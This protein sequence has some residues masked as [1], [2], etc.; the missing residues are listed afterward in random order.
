MKR[1]NER[2][3]RQD[4]AEEIS[5]FWHDTAPKTVIKYLADNKNI[6]V[7]YHQAYYK[8][9]KKVKKWKDKDAE[10]LVDDLN[11]GPYEYAIEFDE[12]PNGQCVL[13]YIS[14]CTRK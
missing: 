2:A 10:K 14:F 5:K 7:T 11:K 13:N 4:I 8:L 1:A 3:N 12:L 9:L 6:K